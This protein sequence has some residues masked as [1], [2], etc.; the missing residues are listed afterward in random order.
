MRID[1]VAGLSTTSTS[2]FEIGPSVRLM[3]LNAHRCALGLGLGLATGVGGLTPASA[4][5]IVADDADANPTSERV[6]HC[7]PRDPAS[8]DF[9]LEGGPLQLST[10]RDRRYPTPG[11]AGAATLVDG[12]W[13]D[14]WETEILHRGAGDGSG[15]GPDL[16]NRVDVVFVGDGYQ[17]NE[18][19]LYA[20]QVAAFA[21]D[22][23]EA[24]PLATYRPLFTIHR[25][26]VVSTDSGVDNDPTEGIDRDTELN[27]RYW[28]NNIERLLCISVGRAYS[29]AE[30]AAIASGNGPDQVIALA[31]SSKYGGAGYSSSDLGTAAAGNGAAVEIV[32][33]ELGHAMGDLADEYT[34][35]GPETYTGGETN[36]ANTSILTE[37]Q[38]SDQ[39]TK[40]SPWLGE[41]TSQFDG[42]HS[43][44]EG[45]G[46]S[47]FGIYRPTNNSK[48]RSLNRPF[49]LVGA[50]AFIQ[51]IYRIVSPIDATVPAAGTGVTEHTTL[52]VTPVEPNGNPLAIQ[53]LLDGEPIPGATGRTLDTCAAGLAGSGTVSVR[54]RDMTPW[55]RDE[56]FRD[57]RMTQTVNFPFTLSAPGDQNG[58]GDV[59]ILDVIAFIATWNAQGPGSDFNNDGAINI[60]DVIGFVQL[61]Q[62]ECP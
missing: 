13:L 30:T 10:D 52:S 51:E 49:N 11:L 46:Y 4:Q 41:N 6:Y 25:V 62:G 27:M 38:M 48:M 55:V 8:G 3:L 18:L 16:A 60:L 50:E 61:W 9:R 5:L 14:R 22:M 1:L 35:G 15:G 57:Q 23:F 7:M 2:S 21:N 12:A 37:A 53:W 17:A 54:V 56:T 43:T 47:R 39:G 32:V 33:H 19:A 59:N 24:E 29:Y 36:R 44:F 45:A 28:C 31:N 20:S 42:L 58:D 26:D 34:Y 40:W